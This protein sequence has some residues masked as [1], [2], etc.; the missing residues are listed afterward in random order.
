MPLIRPTAAMDVLFSFAVVADTHVNEN[1]NDGSSPYLTNA[2]A[3]A[4]ARHV[5]AQIARIQDELAFVVHLGDIV[6]P[7]PGIDGYVPAVENFKAIAAGLRIPLHVV[8]GNHDVGDKRVDWM[9]ADHVC[10]EYLAKYRGFFGPDWFSFE[11]GDS[12]FVFL[13]TV[14]MNS[15]LPEEHE[16][17]Q[18]L[19]DELGRLRGRRI[20]FFM[21][22]PP[23]LH[24]RA[25]PGNY[26]NID[27]P[28]RDWLL[29]RLGREDVEAVFCGHVHNYWL[30]SIGRALFYMLPSTAFMRH[31]FSAFYR[32]APQVEYGR[33]DPG[34]F[35]YFIVDV[36]TDG[37]VAYSV[38]SGARRLPAQAASQAQAYEAA[39]DVPAGLVE[40][41]ARAAA[42]VGGATDRGALPGGAGRQT[43]HTSD[44]LVVAHPAVSG[45]AAVG[46]ELRHPWAQSEQIAATGGVQEFG[47]KF[48]RNDYPLQAMLEMG[49]RLVK[50]PM[51]DY[52]EP[53]S[54]GRLKLLRRM[55]LSAVVSTL[56]APDPGWSDL[57][58]HGVVA[59]EC[60]QPLAAL[61]E[62]ADRASEFRRNS[63][64]M[65]FFA[66]I[67]E[68]HMDARYDGAKFTHAVKAGFRCGELAAH[69]DVIAARVRSGALDGVVVRAEFGDDLAGVAAECAAFAEA[70][71]ARGLISVKTVGPS[72][73]RLND[74]APRLAWL[75]AQAMVLSRVYGDSLWFVFDTFADVDRGYY[76]RHAFIDGHFDP[77]PAGVAW[78][79]LTAL[80]SDDGPPWNLVER[81]DGWI[82]LRT[83]SRT[84]WLAERGGVTLP[85]D[86]RSAAASRAA[87]SVVLGLETVQCAETDAAAAG[88]VGDLPVLVLGP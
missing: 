27:R 10:S 19:D 54:R 43:L 85:A 50:V 29:E 87:R 58:E 23:Y 70:S 16:Q 22:Y 67:R 5:F 26:D 21:H 57:R 2:Q 52:R 69:R 44:E 37:H 88:G 11:R 53:A 41:A 17:A 1:E 68:G 34:R 75:T 6:H 84:L 18:W 86:G 3:N 33:G 82:S 25:E 4:R 15:G 66:P 31:D 30:D 76:P 72:V 14:L 79:Q 35:G 62:P 64:A 60:N 40:A 65:L 7:V 74:D 49:V 42:E 48:A 36:H 24:D 71:G 51:I 39:R 80:L 63:G 20:F 77:R 12:A 8:P 45:F 78:R 9:P 47:R 32:V 83:A 73:A 61:S 59:V 13:N 46:V 56:G 55:G 38:R 28:A 81:G